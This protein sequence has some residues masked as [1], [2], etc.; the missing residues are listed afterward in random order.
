MLTKMHQKLGTAGFVVS[1]VA[2]VAA[3]GGA[4][5]AAGGLTKQQE[6]QVTKIA[7]K[8]AGKPGTNG[9]NGT[10]GKD[11]A[12]GTPGTQGPPGAAGTQGPPGAAGKSVVLTAEPKGTNC[13][14]G[15]T[16]VEVEGNPSKKFV[17][18][19]LTGFTETLPSGKTE[20]GT[21]GIATELAGAPSTLQEVWI[22]IGFSIPLAAA[23]GEEKVFVLT[24]AQIE[25]EKGEGFAAGCKGTAVKPIAPKGILCVYTA[26]EESGKELGN[27]FGVTNGEFGA[28]QTA[29]TVLRAF[30]NALPTRV[31]VNGTWAVTAP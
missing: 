6:K 10:N 28:Y 29:G 4:A 8:Y 22:P 21:W 25:E 20:T 12:P 30:A 27:F 15:G 18:N 3:L 11:G 1:I 23:S 17:C 14:E 5:W 13:P 7:K 31:Q 26:E 16:K 19:G 2:L 24:K 9:T